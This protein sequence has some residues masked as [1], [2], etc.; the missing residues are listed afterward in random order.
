[1]RLDLQA[2][3][4]H[5]SQRLD[6]IEVA[7]QA[8][9]VI[10]VVHVAQGSDSQGRSTLDDREVPIITAYLFHA[11]GH[12]DPAKLAANADKSFQGS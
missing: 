3:R 1:M 7:G 11:G 12:D 2:R 8:A 4:D 9:V 5:L 6:G 10:S